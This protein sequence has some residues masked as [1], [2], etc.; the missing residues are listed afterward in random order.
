MDV[1]EMLLKLV[2]PSYLP[3]WRERATFLAGWKSIPSTPWVVDSLYTMA[4][5]R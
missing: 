5:S 3:G 1:S 4:A 2:I